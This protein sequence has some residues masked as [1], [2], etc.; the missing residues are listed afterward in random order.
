MALRLTWDLER[1]ITSEATSVPYCSASWLVRR[2]GK[3]ACLGRGEWTDNVLGIV[4][5]N[6]CH[7]VH[8]ETVRLGHHSFN[9]AV[10]DM[11]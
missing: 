1:A 3:H 8:A 5:H 4:V 7:A 2:K 11:V 6:D 9:E 10:R